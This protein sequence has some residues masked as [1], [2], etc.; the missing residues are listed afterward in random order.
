MFGGLK[1]SASRL[2]LVAAAGV[3][4]TNAYAADLGGDCCADLEERVAE[5]EATTARK[6]TRK[7][8]L[9]VYGHLNK[10]ILGWNDSVNRNVA[11]G[12]DNVNQSTRFGFRGNAKISPQVSAGYQI[13]IEQ[14]SGGRSTNINQFQDKGAVSGVLPIAGAANAGAANT[15]GYRNNNFGADDAAITMREA[16][17]WIESKSVGRL[18]VGR[19][20]GGA[21]PQ[22]A[23]DLGG[24]GL[25]VAGGSSTVGSGMIFRTNQT[26]TGIVNAQTASATSIAQNGTGTGTTNF[27][28]YTIGNTTDLAGNYST[29]QN[30]LQYT[31]PVLAGFTVTASYSGSGKVDDVDRNAAGFSTRIT[32]LSGRL[33]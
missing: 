9:E 32:V 25:T 8:S 1:K 30:G 12:I 6:G 4:S 2:A 21:G 16:N 7:T 31:S 23:I 13:V 19:F 20:V 29:R 27:T 18:T 15:N 14:N 17:W 33:A 10:I 28:G 3:L 26:S 11:L 5:L 22:G 24:I